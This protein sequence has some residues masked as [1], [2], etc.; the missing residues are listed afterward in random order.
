LFSVDQVDNL[1]NNYYEND[2]DEK[3]STGVDYKNRNI[4]WTIT[5]KGSMDLFS[6]H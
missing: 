5:A 6:F 1:E 3:A 2:V 4:Q